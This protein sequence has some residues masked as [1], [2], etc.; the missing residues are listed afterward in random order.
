MD[1]IDDYGDFL[2]QSGKAPDCTKQRRG[3]A[4][5]VMQEV[6]GDSDDS[7]S[8]IWQTCNEFAYFQTADK[9]Y[10]MLGYEFSYG[11]DITRCQQMFPDAK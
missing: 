7:V 2:V 8:W 3:F 4:Y 5:D 9:M 6:P 1:P 10:R 11:L